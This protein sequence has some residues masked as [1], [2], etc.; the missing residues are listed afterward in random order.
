MPGI[1]LTGPRKR[2]R[3]LLTDEVEIRLPTRKVKSTP[4]WPVVQ[5]EGELVFRG[6]AFV[7]YL[8]TTAW[9][10]NDRLEVRTGM[11]T[12]VNRP[13]VFLAHDSPPVPV[14]AEIEVLSSVDAQNVGRRFRV[15]TVA[16]QSLVVWRQLIVEEVEL[17]RG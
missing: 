8:P 16:K 3:K 9:E 17:S 11:E 5:S 14:G 13:S 10:E 12:T 4:G 6:V 15:I 7:A 1:N 2:V